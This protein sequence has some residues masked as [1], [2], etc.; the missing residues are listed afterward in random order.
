MA[1]AED[2]PGRK[3][4]ILLLV[5][6]DQ[7]PDTISALGNEHIRTPHLD[8]LAQ[9]GLVFTRA[10]CA[11]P[12]CF[13]SRAEL[14]TGSTGWRNGSFAG[15]K[16]NAEV[17][18]LPNLLAAAGYQT[19]YVGKWHTAGRPSTVGYAE[20]DGLFAGG[21]QSDDA[22]VDFRGRPATGYRGWVFQT[23]DRKLFPEKGIGLTPDI[24]AEFA[25]A[26]IR[27]IE[28]KP[29]QPFFLHVN[30]TAPHDPRLWPTKSDRRPLPPGE[31]DPLS[32]RA[33]AALPPLP[34]NFQA[35]HSFDHGN[36]RG[37]DELLL[38]FPRTEEDVRQELACYYATIE[39]LDEQIG[40]IV[41]ALDATGQ[42]ENTLIV[43]TSDHGLAVGSHGLVGKQNM[44]EH[45]IN[46]PLILSGPGVPVGKQTAA[47][48]YLRDLLPTFCELAGARVPEKI[49]GRSLLPIVRD[50]AAE[51]HPFLVGYFQDSQRMIRKGD[52][53]LIWYPKLDRR[54]LFNVA[55][56][57]HELDDQSMHP[58]Q[59]ERIAQLETELLK[60]LKEHA[61]S[62]VEPAASK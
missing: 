47:Q 62:L 20:G 32:R 25:D 40:R 48:C 54:Q 38:P 4:N 46:V 41:T 2:L 35:E 29:V 18:L 21:G 39:H 52:W 7:R 22:Y 53:K 26:A 1:R 33:H 17:P 60:W 58:E 24:S 34:A 13:P 27:F 36:A 11:H 3:P 6:D 19:W 28:R 50:P 61:D 42:R 10:T 56:D 49:D 12:L 43:F 8:E 9:Q 16:L 37:R 23:D 44:Y 55:H 5:S 59:R 31:S 14:L 45:T 15:L 57:P 51:V 30:F